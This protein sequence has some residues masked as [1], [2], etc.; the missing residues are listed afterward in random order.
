MKELLNSDIL[1]NAAV[2]VFAIIGVLTTVLL[3]FKQI[4][5]LQVKR[6]QKGESIEIELLRKS[7][8]DRI[9]AMT[10]KLLASGARWED[11]NHLLIPTNNSSYN[12][13]LLRKPDKVYLSSFLKY[14]G[15]REPDLVIQKDMV[16]VLMP[17][18][19]SFQKSFDVIKRTC[20]RMGLKSYR[21]DES[22]IKGEIL[23]HIIKQIA[24]S[25]LIIANID[26]RNANVYY[27]LGIAHAMDKPVLMIASSAENLSFDL[28]SKQIIIYKGLEDL[29]VKLRDSLTRLLIHE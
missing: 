25:R 3:Y 6:K 23:P 13:L 22:F 1:T 10:E 28:Q 15:L 16:F 12:E 26:G 27:E 7:Y 11:I 8:E 21:G 2:V 9:Y 17:L 5:D 19:P 14:A 18:N 24:Q 4:R 20:E 29:Q